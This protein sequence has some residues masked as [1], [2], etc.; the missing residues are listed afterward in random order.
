MKE[1]HISNFDEI[2]NKREHFFVTYLAHGVKEGD[3]YVF[4]N[5]DRRIKAIV[6]E[7]KENKVIWEIITKEAI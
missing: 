4:L 7:I 1:A 6:S 3:E 5:F 2:W